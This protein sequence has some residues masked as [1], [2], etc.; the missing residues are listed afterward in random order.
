MWVLAAAPGKVLVRDFREPGTNGPEDEG[1]SD[2]L[3]GH[4]G[5]FRTLYTHMKN[6][7]SKVRPGKRVVLAQRLGQISEIGNAEGSHLHHGHFRDGPG[8]G[9]PIKMRIMGKELDA[10]LGNSLTGPVPGGT[11][12][13]DDRFRGP[14]FRAILR[15]R[16]RRHSDGMKS[17]WR[18]LRFVVARVDDPVPDCVD[19]G[20]P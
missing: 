10:S 8:F 11:L 18:Q 15:V 1:V 2:V 4:P 3:I 19:P 5:G 6:I 20:C 12:E 16:V 9:R 13:P 7:S 14:V 17:R